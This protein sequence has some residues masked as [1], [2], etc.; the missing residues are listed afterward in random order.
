MKLKTITKAR[1]R[2]TIMI[3][4]AIAIIFISIGF[5]TKNIQWH[6]LAFVIFGIAL[7]RKYW[8]MKRLK[9]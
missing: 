3:Y 1:N 9:D 2:K 5:Y 8:L 6:F 4:Y 7:F